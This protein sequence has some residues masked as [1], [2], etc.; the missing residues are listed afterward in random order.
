MRIL[1]VTP[2]TFGDPTFSHE[3]SHE[4]IRRTIDGRTYVLEGLDGRFDFAGASAGAADAT[5]ASAG[6]QA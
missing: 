2:L 5:G 4:R 6:R 3:I 1:N